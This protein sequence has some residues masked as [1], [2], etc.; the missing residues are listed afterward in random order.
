M[1]LLE[2]DFHS[3][4]LRAA[5]V[6]STAALLLLGGCSKKS[7][8][9]GDVLPPSGSVVVS[10]R[11]LLWHTD[12][13]ARGFVRYGLQRDHLD[14]VAYPEAVGRRDR[15]FVE[16]HEVALLDV[17]MGAS[18]YYQ[19]GVETRLSGPRFAA[20]DSFRS[21]VGPPAG[22]LTSAM[23]HIG[24]GDAHV[25]T[26][27]ITGRH[28]LIDAGTRDAATSVRQYLQERGISSFE[29]ML[30]THVHIDHL[31]GIIGYDKGGILASNPPSIFYDSPRKDAGSSKFAYSEVQEMVADEGVDEV[32]LHRFDT[33]TTVASLRWD[34]EV[35]VT[36]LNSGTPDDYVEDGYEG[37]DI[38]NES[39]VLLFSYG[40]VQFI[41][42]GDAEQEAEA[43]MLAAFPPE[44]LEVEYYKAH[45]HGLPDASS[46]AWVNTLN[47]RVAFI[48]NTAW[49]WNGDLEGALSQTT[50]R[51]V[52][53]G[54]QIYVIDDVPMI[55]QPRSMGIQHNITFATDGVSYEVRVETAQ[56][57]APHKAA[58]TM[59]CIHGD[60]DLQG[61][62]PRY[63]QAVME[64]QHVGAT[65]G[66]RSATADS[67]QE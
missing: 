39:I 41:I 33:S 13:P 67:H 29:G 21:Q 20:L 5:V 55:G 14:H 28:V 32:V 30:A 64:G 44:H 27:P 43:S 7:P 6:L 56:Q 65:D 53:V 25:L 58:S 35:E 18:V 15:A 31:G 2:R 52:N 19:I 37:T 57:T 36:V 42:G 22:V 38:N 23:V 59:S 11:S 49:S 48:P 9:E 61:L 40:D 16:D 46:T 54:A 51:L 45:H 34:P 47:P 66:S 63:D 1:T 4:F 26:M 50:G 24:F 60:P 8:V 3:I 12:E 17:D 10:G 62:F